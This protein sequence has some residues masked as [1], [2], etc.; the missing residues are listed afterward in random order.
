MRQ[1]YGR[2]GTTVCIVTPPRGEGL[3]SG[4]VWS[5]NHGIAIS[6]QIGVEQG[7]GLIYLLVILV[8]DL[9]VGE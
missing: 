5:F 1:R 2:S 4:L 9:N 3:P 8:L 6:T 7:G